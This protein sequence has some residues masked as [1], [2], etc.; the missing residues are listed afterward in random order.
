MATYRTVHISF[1]TDPK[2]DD[3]FTPEDKYFYLYLLT[4][5]HTNI[6]GCYEISMKQMVRETGYN[7]DT[8]KR[9]LNRMEYTHNVIQ[10]D[11]ST[12]EVFIP[13]WGKYN[14]FNSKDTMAGVAKVVSCIKSERFKEAIV[15]GPLMGVYTPPQGGGGTSVTVTDT[16]S[17]K[18]KRTSR[19][20]PPTLEEVQNYVSENGLNVDADKFYQ[21]FT[22]PD[23]SGR[24]WIDSNGNPVR[25]W[26][27]KLITWSTKNG[28]EIKKARKRN[29]LLNYKESGDSVAKC[30]D[31]AAD[32]DDDF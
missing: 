15:Q 11:A 13:R 27:Q 6:C 19:F 16:V 5:P 2:V 10:Y 17:V 30:D 7:E 23:D 14:W 12:K 21:Y 8:V 29:T 31:I 22:T 26:K 9:L 28:G 25:N 32:I 18:S 20:T 24:T 1:W 3:D 4:N